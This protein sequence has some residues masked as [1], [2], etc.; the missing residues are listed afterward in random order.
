MIILSCEKLNYPTFLDHW[1]NYDYASVWKQCLKHF[2][3]KITFTFLNITLN[4]SKNSV[5]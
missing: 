1:K 3:F 2:G 4:S 5:S